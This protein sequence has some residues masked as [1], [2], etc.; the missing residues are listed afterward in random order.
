M[1]PKHPPSKRELKRLKRSEELLDSALRLLS[2]NGLDGFSLHKLARA[3]GLTVGALYRYFPSKGALIAALEDRVIEETARRLERV[4]EVAAQQRRQVRAEIYPLGRFV[5][6]TYAYR[7]RLHA[8]PEQMRL[9][10]GL[11]SNPTPMLEQED[12]RRVLENM[13]RSLTPVREAIDEGVRLA[14]LQRGDGV[15]RALLTWTAL[16]GAA[17]TRKLTHRMPE[18]FDEDALFE[19]AV[20]TLLLGW[21]A[22]PDAVDEAFQFAHALTQEGS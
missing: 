9:I 5:A 8:A 19:L 7:A 12:A 22:H 21:G 10:G 6:L 15:Q 2:E 1:N 18:I 16:R 3:V 4:L 11:M 17:E 14:M 13:L 20:R